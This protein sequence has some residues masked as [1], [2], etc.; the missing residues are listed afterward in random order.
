[1]IPK[2]LVIE[3][4]LFVCFLQGF[5]MTSSRQASHVAYF[6]NSLELS[7]TYDADVFSGTKK[8]RKETSFEFPLEF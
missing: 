5:V 6:S 3:D 4:L 2:Y 8:K 1:M 7:F